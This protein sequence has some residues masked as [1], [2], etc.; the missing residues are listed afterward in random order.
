MK[1]HLQFRFDQFPEHLSEIFLNL[2]SSKGLCDV[3]L[4]GEDD[5]P[6]EAHKVILSAFSRVLKHLIKEKYEP[7]MEIK[8]QGMNNNDIERIIQFMYLGKVSV[9]HAGVDKFL[10]TAKFLDLSQLSDRCKASFEELNR[11]FSISKVLSDVHKSNEETT[12]K[13]T[14]VQSTEIVPFGLDKVSS[15]ADISNDEE[16]VDT[17]L[18]PECHE[19]SFNE[20]M[21]EFGILINEEEDYEEENIEND[22]SKRNEE[23]VT[24]LLMD[25][26]EETGIDEP[27]NGNQLIKPESVD[28]GNQKKLNEGDGNFTI[29]EPEPGFNISISVL[30]SHHYFQKVDKNRALCL[31]CLQTEGS[32]KIFKF[33]YHNNKQNYK[34]LTQHLLCKHPEFSGKFKSQKKQIDELRI[35]RKKAKD[36]VV[37]RKYKTSKVSVAPIFDEADYTDVTIGQQAPDFNLISSVY[38]SCN[39]FRKVRTEDGSLKSFCLMCWKKEKK[40]TFLSTPGASSSFRTHLASKHAE[41]VDEY[42]RQSQKV[43]EMRSVKRQR[44]EEFYREESTRKVELKWERKQIELKKEKNRKIKDQKFYEAD[45]FDS[46]LFVNLENGKTVRVGEPSDSNNPLD[47]DTLFKFNYFEK[48]IDDNNEQGSRCLICA[49]LVEEGMEPQ[50]PRNS[51]LKKGKKSHIKIMHPAIYE[52]YFS[53]DEKK[54]K[55]L[56]E[57]KRI[58]FQKA[59]EK[60]IQSD[61]KLSLSLSRNQEDDDIDVESILEEEFTIGEPSPKFDINKSVYFSHNYYRKSD[62]GSKALCLMC[63]RSKEKKKLLLKVT[64]GNTKGMLGHMQS[65]HIDYAKNYSLQSKIIQSMRIEKRQEKDKNRERIKYVS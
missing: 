52:N 49:A 17:E 58:Q 37:L 45:L 25:N 56:R 6:V 18:E 63:L 22:I 41:F 42:V 11:E 26:V 38:F 30:I 21:N 23:A 39:F 15:E 1:A 33:A 51:I 59:Q 48:V 62:K 5:I 16:T 7:V 65:F 2:F 40:K 34:G 54:T 46:G 64:S 9:A 60:M 4:I 29:G 47:T 13:E 53:L 55:R 44:Q 28:E 61:K 57:E 32:R 10:R 35:N 27:M 3:R 19:E 24:N 50:N 43:N 8:I 36:G 20:D 12:L 14:V 31:V